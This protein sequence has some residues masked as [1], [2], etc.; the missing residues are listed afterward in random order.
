MRTTKLSTEGRITLPSEL[1]ARKKWAKGTMFQVSETEDGVLL[2]PISPF[3]P[4]RIEDVFASA[5]YHGPKRSLD[6]MDAA[7]R[8]DKRSSS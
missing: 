5:R 4:T 2:K 6:D 1:C 7:E 3:A 8:K